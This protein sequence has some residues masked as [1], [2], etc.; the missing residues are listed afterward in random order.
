MKE[1]KNETHAYHLTRGLK[2]FDRQ[3]L[4]MLVVD[5]DQMGAKEFLAEH[6]IVID[7]GEDPLRV[8]STWTREIKKGEQGKLQIRFSDKGPTMD[9]SS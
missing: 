4:D 3:V 2:P 5:K 6:G 1:T 8:C 9:I 7:E